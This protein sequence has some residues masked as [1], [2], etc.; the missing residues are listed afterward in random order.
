MKKY[1]DLI[2][3]FDCGEQKPR[4]D[5]HRSSLLNLVPRCAECG[6]RRSKEW[7]AKNPEKVRALNKKYVT[8]RKAASVKYEDFPRMIACYDCGDRKE[9][10]KFYLS[11]LKRRDYMCKSCSNEQTNRYRRTRRRIAR[12]LPP[13]AEAPRPRL[14]DWDAY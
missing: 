14:P 2:T 5:Y 9:R 1:G 12:G 3:C 7:R 13:K 6:N 4:R 8:R 10:E 11:K